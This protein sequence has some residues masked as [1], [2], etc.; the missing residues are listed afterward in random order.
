MNSIQHLIF[1]SVTSVGLQYR[2]SS[3]GLNPPKFFPLRPSLSFSQKQ[4]SLFLFYKK[5]QK[6]IFPPCGAL[7]TAPG[8]QLLALSSWLLDH[9]GALLF[10]SLGGGDRAEGNH[11]A[12][13][14]APANQH[15]R[16]VIYLS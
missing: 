6:I 2:F 5:R 3:A 1:F 7:D 15:V 16:W 8:L 14:L 4:K 13:A 12:F 9:E 10:V 11:V